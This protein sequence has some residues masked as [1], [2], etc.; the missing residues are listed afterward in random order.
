M[1]WGRG[2]TDDRGRGRADEG[3]PRNGCCWVTVAGASFLR[4]LGFSERRGEWQRSEFEWLKVGGE[5]SL[6][7]DVNEKPL[8]FNMN[9]LM[10]AFVVS[11][12]GKFVQ[13]IEGLRQNFL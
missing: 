4:A 8:H 6:T 5:P 7:R 3:E 11:S 13:D 1:A 9:G 2:G 12:R 10:V